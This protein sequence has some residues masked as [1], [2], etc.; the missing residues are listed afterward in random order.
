MSKQ[1]RFRLQEDEIEILESYRAIKIES[2]VM[3]L[4]DTDVKHGW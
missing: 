3:G 4:D 2:N 1:T